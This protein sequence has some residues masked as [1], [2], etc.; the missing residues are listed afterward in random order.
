MF[1]M[2]HEYFNLGGVGTVNICTVCANINSPNTT[3]HLHSITDHLHIQDQYH[4][5]LMIEWEQADSIR[6]D[7]IP[8]Q[9]ICWVQSSLHLHLGGEWDWCWCLFP[10]SIYL[11]IFIM[12]RIVCHSDSN[13]QLSL[14]QFSI[15]LFEKKHKAAAWSGNPATNVHSSPWSDTPPYMVDSPWR[16][17]N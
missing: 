10:W 8:C 9:W 16:S 11:G 14:C 17:A 1:V 2:H 13:V 7:T 15:F 3:T 4:P 12:Y 6:G 5:V